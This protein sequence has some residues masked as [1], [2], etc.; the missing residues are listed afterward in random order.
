MSFF[1][2]AQIIDKIQQPTKFTE[3]LGHCVIVSEFFLFVSYMNIRAIDG[4]LSIYCIYKFFYYPID[5]TGNARY[6]IGKFSKAKKNG[7]GF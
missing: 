3:K 2:I 5:I 1:S 7:V 4:K 6:N